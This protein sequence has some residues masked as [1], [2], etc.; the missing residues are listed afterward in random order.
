[1]SDSSRRKAQSWPYPRYRQ[2]EDTVRK[3]AADWFEEKGFAIHPRYSYIL[4]SLDHWQK[5][6]IVSNVADYIAK[7]RTRREANKQGFPLHKYAHHGLSSQAMLFNLVGPLIVAS[8]F[9]PLLKVVERKGLRLSGEISGA[10]LEYED[11]KV[12]N[13]DTG[14]P[15]S[16]DLVIETTGH[17]PAL[18]I[19]SKMVEREFG[20]CSVFGMGDCDGRNPAGDLSNCYL[21]FIGR[22][23][24]ELLEKFG[25]LDG[26]MGTE[27]VCPLALHYQFFR[28]L[29]FALEQGGYFIL[30]YD[31]RNPT[32][33]CKG[34]SVTRGLI[35]LLLEFVP[36]PYRPYVKTITM[37]EVAAEIRICGRHPWIEE[38]EKK[39]GL[40]KS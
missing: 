20:G 2:Y 8:E 21:H 31:E 7:E 13:E 40:V 12:F 10:I 4:D 32:F 36:E 26:P 38:F 35:P 6:I 37:Q 18:F 1:M 29:L 24:W 19:E 17:Q 9:D 14:Q 33:F 25:F 27:K 16:I 30:L 3:A 34:D 15:T 22:R 5:N 23:Y 28:E 39:H 11:R